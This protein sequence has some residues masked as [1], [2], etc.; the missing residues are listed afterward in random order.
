MIFLSYKLFA[1]SFF[2]NIQEKNCILILFW[3]K[4]FIQ[5]K[6]KIIDLFFLNDKKETIREDENKYILL[7]HI[8]WNIILIV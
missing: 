4:I 7:L 8:F 1:N 5:M 6:N 3:K 2:M